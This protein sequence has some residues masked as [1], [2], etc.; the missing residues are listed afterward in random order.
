MVSI[1]IGAFRLDPSGIRSAALFWLAID[2]GTQIAR[3]V[4][5]VVGGSTMATGVSDR[6]V[7]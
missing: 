2:M 6:M 3:A 1:A 4:V 5:V 7:G